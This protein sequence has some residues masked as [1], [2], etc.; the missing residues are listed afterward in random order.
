MM[1]MK[2]PLRPGQGM[3]AAVLAL[4]LCAAA[5]QAQTPQAPDAAQ[6][7]R[8]LESTSTLIERSSGAKQVEASGGADAAA[9]RTRARELHATAA[10]AL[11]AGRLDEAAKLLDDASRAMFESVRLAAPQ[12]LIARKQRTDFDARMESTRALL[13]AQKR[14]AAEKSAGPRAGELSREVE[15]LMAQA[16]ATAERGQLVEA[17]RTLDQAYLAVRTAIGNL[18]GGDTIVRTLNFASKAEEYLYEIDRNDAH[19]MLV[20]MLLKDKRGGATDT[21]VDHAVAEAAR[22]R[23]Q[24][25]DEAGRRNHEAAVRTLEESTRELVKAIRGAG[26]YIP[27]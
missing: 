2:T 12:T 8:K 7:Q 16:S 24:A 14:I 27:G 13:E 20:Q 23:A 17:R 9:Q 22:L 5:V 18:R 11:K 19:R 3:R 10:E 26:V 1:T 21:M 15:S 4:G 6:L 25:E